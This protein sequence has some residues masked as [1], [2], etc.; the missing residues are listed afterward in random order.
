MGTFVDAD[1]IQ[2][3]M[4][5]LA[6][7]CLMNREKLATHVLKRPLPDDEEARRQARDR[8]YEAI[9]REFNRRVDERVRD[10]IKHQQP[11]HI[12]GR[13]VYEMST[14]DLIGIAMDLMR[15]DINHTLD[16]AI[17]Q[18]NPKER[19]HDPSLN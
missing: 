15:D 12:E 7:V 2:K 10:A 14:E 6:A 8:M 19:P 16:E 4:Q 9:T 18:A 17:E 5:H 13:D 3:L 11:A 1:L